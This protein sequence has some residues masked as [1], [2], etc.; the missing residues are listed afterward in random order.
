VEPLQRTMKAKLDVSGKK[1]MVYPHQKKCFCPDL[2]LSDLMSLCFCLK[3][4]EKLY[5]SFIGEGSRYDGLVGHKSE[6]R[7]NVEENMGYDLYESE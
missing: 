6:V 3:P 7:L 2:E 5:D 4:E 1:A